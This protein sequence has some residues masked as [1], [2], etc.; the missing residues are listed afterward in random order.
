MSALWS[1]GE[2]GECRRLFRSRRIPELE[3]IPE[4]WEPIK[5]GRRSGAG[6][7]EVKTVDGSDRGSGGSRGLCQVCREADKAKCA[8]LSWPRKEVVAG[9]ERGESRDLGAFEDLQ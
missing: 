1:E 5:F 8:R 4:E 9:F 3:P 2:N 7:R 6:A